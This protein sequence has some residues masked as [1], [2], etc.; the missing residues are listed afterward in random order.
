MKLLI[1]GLSGKK[2]V[3]KDAAGESMAATAQ[4]N[5]WHTIRRGFG[6]AVK[7]EVA[8]FLGNH[9]MDAVAKFLVGQGV[10]PK[11]KRELMR[12]FLVAPMTTSWWSRI[13]RFFCIG[14]RESYQGL[15][16][17]VREALDDRRRKEHFRPWMQWWG[18]E[19][20]RKADPSYWQKRMRDFI[21]EIPLPPA[22]EKYPNPEERPVLL[23]VPDNRFPNE[24]E[25]LL[26][27]NA[28]TV[29]LN[30]PHV[31]TGDPHPSETALDACQTFHAVLN[32]AEDTS[33]AE[34]RAKAA[35]AFATAVGWR[36]G[37]APL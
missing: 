17:Y 19:Y 10:G 22:N 4:A 8:D 16:W 15:D 21:N 3:G 29:R 28:F 32:Q 2:G 6:D 1:I 27:Q 18:T 12:V 7:D 37:S 11:I 34:L 5:G 30:R 35:E 9:S 13:R 25:F 26:G 31:D 23:W 20:R 33:L 36:F 24:Q 14:R